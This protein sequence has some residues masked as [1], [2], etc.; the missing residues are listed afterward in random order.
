MAGLTGVS[1]VGKNNGDTNAELEV[2][3][4]QSDPPNL[5]HGDM[6]FVVPEARIRGDDLSSHP[7]L[8]AAK[9]LLNQ[10][11][12]TQPFVITSAAGLSVK[13]ESVYEAVPFAAQLTLTDPNQLRSITFKPL[14]IVSKRFSQ[15]T[16]SSLYRILQSDLWA[17][18]GTTTGQGASDINSGYP[19]ADRRDS[20]SS[21][22]HAKLKWMVMCK[23]IDEDGKIE[24][25]NHDSLMQAPQGS[26]FETVAEAKGR[27]QKEAAYKQ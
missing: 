24:W 2:T 7:T 4:L 11:Y 6:V 17:D 18:N 27:Q 25:L 12:W 10:Q 1:I 15:K 19:K 21:S 20:N 14:S 16:T 13:G 22:S 8:S 5:E 26:I 9:F 3:F 23:I